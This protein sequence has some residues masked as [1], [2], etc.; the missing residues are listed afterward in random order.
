MKVL[1]AGIG[2]V[3]LGDDGFGVETVRRLCSRSLPKD[4]W[5]KDFGLRGFDLACSISGE[6][7][8]VILVD[9]VHRSEAPG[10]VYVIELDTTSALETGGPDLEP[11]GLD[12]R[13][14]IQLA[15]IIGTVSARL[16]LVGCEPAFVGGDDGL[17]GL[18]AP[19]ENAV[20]VA[21]TT[22]ERIVSRLASKQDWN[23]E[24]SSVSRTC[25]FVQTTALQK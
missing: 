11:H 21:I 5:V 20:E 17:W 14:A 15:G 2:N 25:K 16:M 8:L 18:S 19:V 24:Q 13:R 9:A 12:P 10:S 6:W 23:Q 4:V 22:I 7:D 3:F 1:I